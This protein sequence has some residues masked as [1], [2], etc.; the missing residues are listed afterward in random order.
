[1]SIETNV[2]SY[3]TRGRLE[4]SIL[5]ALSKAGKDL[6]Q[7]T[8][9]DLAA[10]DEFHVGGREA[11][12]ELATQMEL[13]PGLRLLDAGS[14]VGG[15]ARY[16]AAEHGCLVTGIDLTEEFVS[17]ARSLTRRTKL[18]HVAEF[19]HG[20][21]LAMPF[22]NATFD[23]A[24]TIH[25]CMNIPDK[26][27]LFKEVRRVLKPGG[28][29]AIFDLMRIG[30][31]PIRYP[32]PWAPTEETSFVSHVSDYRDVLSAVGFHVTGERRRGAFALEFM[33]RM[34]A[35]MAQGGPPVLGLHL[36][37]GEQTKLLLSN[38]QS[39]IQEGILEP[40]ELIAQAA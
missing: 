24:Y 14:G 15:P 7:L 19:R 21:A 6:A 38:V 40:V 20:S 27:G 26:P 28:L 35:R 3:Y 10:F 33:Q 32:V 11:T 30:E 5:Q 34:M 18:D 39:M 16:F 36:L 25:V 22:E 17:V 37:M 8:H 2:A 12:Q 29:F 1:M 13:R 9:G 23:R 4:D 31:G